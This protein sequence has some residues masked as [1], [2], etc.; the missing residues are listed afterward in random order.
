MKYLASHIS[1][2]NGA[3]E[4]KRQ[5]HDPDHEQRRPDPC[6]SHT[7]IFQTSAVT[8]IISTEKKINNITA[9]FFIE[10]MRLSC[11][12]VKIWPSYLLKVDFFTKISL[13]PLLRQAHW[14]FTNAFGIR[15][16]HSLGIVQSC[17]RDGIFSRFDR[18]PACDR[19]TDIYMTV[20]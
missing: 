15:K 9:S 3:P 14:N 12:V 19:Q 6:R 13:A 10:H 4:L 7:N 18:S 11:I 1:R 20:V 16:L 17:V 5:S 8:C 2:Y